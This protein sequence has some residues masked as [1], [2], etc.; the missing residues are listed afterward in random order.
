MIFGH[1]ITID[2]AGIWD[3][4]G[5]ESFLI[6]ILSARRGRTTEE[7]VL[8]MFNLILRRFHANIKNWS[9]SVRQTAKE[10]FVLS[11]PIHLSLIRILYSLHVSWV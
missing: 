4:S 2:W 10:R 3:L 5:S 7:A 11:P 9:S 6:K 8:F 1:Y